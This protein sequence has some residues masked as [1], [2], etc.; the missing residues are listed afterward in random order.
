MA[1]IARTFLAC[2]LLFVPASADA[3]ATFELVFTGVDAATGWVTF[4]NIGDAEPTDYAITSGANVWA[5][6][7]DVQ[8][9]TFGTFWT[10]DT[11]TFF[12]SNPII[13]DTDP[14][15]GPLSR[16]GLTSLTTRYT[17]DGVLMGTYAFKPPGL[18][19]WS[20]SGFSAVDNNVGFEFST[21]SS[22]TVTELGYFDFGGDGLVASHEVGLWRVGDQALLVSGTVSAGS[23][24]RRVGDYRYVDV[25]P[26]LLPPGS[27]VVS[28]VASPALPGTGDPYL[29]NVAGPVMGGPLTFVAGFAASPV[30]TAS[31]VYPNSGPTNSHA[32]ANFGYIEGELAPV[33]GLSSIGM[34]LLV[35]G[36]ATVGLWG[37]AFGRA[38]AR[39]FPGKA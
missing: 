24:A 4:A 38:R 27:Y 23:M 22:I 1:R 6:P 37:V 17:I 9:T 5:P 11:P 21:A 34:T 30:E 3:D 12:G 26:T 35:V 33:P 2:L 28:A 18:V 31:L 16:L 7:D 19:G 8:G 20:T 10:G 25:S 36:L 29:T 32:A 13:D 15:G 39:R 14:P